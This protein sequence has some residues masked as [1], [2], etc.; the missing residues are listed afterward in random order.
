MRYGIFGDVHGN[1]E[2]LQA[3]VGAMANERIDTYLCLGDMVGYGADPNACCEL[4]RGMGAICLFG[5]HDQACLGMVS[6]EWFNAYARAAA[7]WTAA[8]LSPHHREWLAT[9]PPIRRV[10]DLLLVH[11]SLPDP[12][13]WIY[14]TTTALA[15]DT[16]DACTNKLILFGHTHIAEAYRRTGDEAVERASLRV[17]GYINLQDDSRY[18]VNVGSCGQ[19]RDQNPQAAYGVYDTDTARIIVRRVPYDLEQAGAK[20][21]RAGL[22]EFLARRLMVGR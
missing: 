13:K 16:F 9:L 7:E 14:I 18:L 4:I 22:P 20:I 12:W 1:L 11:S 8:T 2:G 21:I 6:L 5:N 3:V 17:G 19:P 15:A 10:A